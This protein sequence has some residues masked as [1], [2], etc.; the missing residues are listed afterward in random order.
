MI[1]QIYLATGASS[2]EPQSQYIELFNKGTT[3][4]NASSF[5]LQYAPEA[6]F[7]WQ[8][9]PLS[10]NIAP[11]QYYLIRL[12][13]LSGG[14]V[15]LPQPDLTI[16]LTLPQT[17]GKVILANGTSAFGT[18]CPQGDP[19]IIDLVGYGNTVC[20]ESSP[21][22]P[23][24]A[25]D[26]LAL[27]RKGGGCV[28]TD[29]N[30][31]DFTKITPVLRNTS[32]V[33]NPCG[34]SVGPRSFVIADGGGSSFQTLGTS[35]APLTTAYARIQPDAGSVA[36][37]G[38]AIYGLRQSGTLIT[39]TGV[40]AT[41]LVTA[42]MLYAEVSGSV[43]TGLAIAN[44]NN[45]DV[46]FSFTITDSNSTQNSFSGS[47]TIA[48]NT[49]MSKFLTDW[50]FNSIGITGIL[51]FTASA[52]VGV[53]TLRGFRNERGEFL[54]STLPVLDPTVPEPTTPSYVPQFAVG[55]GWRTELI[56]VNTLDS[57][58]SGTV[59]FTDGSGN[60]ISVPVGTVTSGLSSFTYTVLQSR[61]LKFILPN[62]NPTLQSGVI[63]IT[64]NSGDRTPIPLA[65]FAYTRDSVRVSEATVLGL[66]ATQLRTYIETSNGGAVDSIKTG[67]AISNAGGGTATVTL[68]AFQLNGVSTNATS[69]LSI[70]AGGRVA[71]YANEMFPTLPA[72]F[73]GVLRLGSNTPVTVAGLRA[74][75]NARGDYLISTVPIVQETTQGSSA[76]I[77]FPHIVD[78]AGYT[79][80]FALI[81][82]VSGQPSSGTFRVRT[83]GGQV[84]DLPIQ[85]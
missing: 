46:T 70:P 72:S 80:Q 52:P 28:D 27:V 21:L 71:R 49:Q 39:E 44:P 67:L 48:A 23:P 31:G 7:T 13:G 56:L 26:I 51:S 25:T 64:P 14:F 5:S 37:A 11:G 18:F 24:Q 55:G 84:L 65:V 42:G 9:F 4:V 74:R 10:G 68:E 78:G 34:G 62:V 43:T 33:R 1:S 30:A 2:T 3:T 6:S 29:F 19:S 50:P 53:T 41:P 79:T 20:F 61:T 82:A 75:N 60:P 69:T 17:A 77:E 57:Q 47:F 15:S 66:Q 58:V 40:P 85:Q 36:P 76:E 22:I 12:T 81:N 16:S 8:A 73:K 63:R 38:V 83:V 35:S 54:V 45:D 32:S 59:S